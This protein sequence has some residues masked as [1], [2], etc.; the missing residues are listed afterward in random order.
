[1]S[2]TRYQRLAIAAEII[3][4][5]D[6]VTLLYL[7][8]VEDIYARALAGEFDDEARVFIGEVTA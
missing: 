2:L 5:A 4:R 3:R 6:T 8:E 1:M 7:H